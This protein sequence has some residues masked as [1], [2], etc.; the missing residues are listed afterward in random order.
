MF[1]L[2]IVSKYKLL[3]IQSIMR[4]YASDSGLNYCLWL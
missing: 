1:R 4:N 3:S 2:I